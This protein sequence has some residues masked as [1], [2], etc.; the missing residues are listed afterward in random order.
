MKYLVAVLLIFQFGFTQDVNST[1]AYKTVLRMKLNM[2]INPV[3]YLDGPQSSQMNKVHQ[4]CVEYLD[5]YE[6]KVPR[7]QLRTQAKIIN[8]RAIKFSNIKYDQ[9]I[10]TKVKK[11]IRYNYF[12]SALDRD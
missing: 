3:F 5:L 10:P 12:S 2:D 4:S 1:E 8:E 11:N 6:D 9:D 7:Q